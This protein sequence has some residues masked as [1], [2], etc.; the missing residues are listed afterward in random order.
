MVE[1]A[2]RIENLA[3]VPAS[4]WGTCEALFDRFAEAAEHSRFRGEIYLEAHRGTPIVQVQHK[5]WFRGVNAPCR[6]GKQPQR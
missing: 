6:P 5:Q 3:G 4:R 2:K 1:R